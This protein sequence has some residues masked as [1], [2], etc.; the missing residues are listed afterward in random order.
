MALV[1]NF[2]KSDREGNWDLR[3]LIVEELLPLLAAFDATNYLCWYSIYL[4]HFKRLPVTDP[5]ILDT[6]CEGYFVVEHTLGWQHWNDSTE[7][8]YHQMGADLS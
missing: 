6:F 1:G 3:I 7:R 2:I 8:F 5:D 4:G